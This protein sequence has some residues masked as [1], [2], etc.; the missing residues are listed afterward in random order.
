MDVQNLFKSVNHYWSEIMKTSENEP[1]YLPVILLSI[2]NVQHFFKSV[3]KHWSGKVKKMK[4]LWKEELQE[5]YFT[6]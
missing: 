4:L 3:Y 2:H 5:N 1:Q 6:R